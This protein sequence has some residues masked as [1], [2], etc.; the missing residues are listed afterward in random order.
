[1]CWPWAG[2]V[3]STSASA[4]VERG[5]QLDPQSLAVQSVS[6]LI[7]HVIYGGRV[8]SILWRYI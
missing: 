7:G 4:D 1:M 5:G 6:V 3:L 2:T 8:T